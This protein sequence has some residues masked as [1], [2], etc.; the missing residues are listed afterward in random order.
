MNRIWKK[1]AA[2][3]A[4]LMI[5]AGIPAAPAET[6]HREVD[7]PEIEITAELGYD[8]VI[9]YGKAI[10]VRVRIRNWGADLEGVLGVN[11]YA[12]VREYNRYEIP[13]SVPSG[14]EKEYVLPVSVM[15]LQETFTP[16]IVVDGKVVEAVNIRAESVYNPSA[17][18]VGVLSTRPQMLSNMTITQE[19]DAL[20]RYEY[21][22]TVPLTADTF[23]D[24][25]ALMDA[26]GILVIDDIDPATLT[27]R[28]QAVLDQ[29]LRDGHFVLCGGGA[30]AARNTAYFSGITGLTAGDTYTSRYVLSALETFTGTRKTGKAP[31]VT[32]A[33]L[34]GADPVISGE[35]GQGLVYRTEAGSGRIYTM[36]F[37]AAESRMNTESVMHIFW[38]QA[39]VRFDS[40]RYNTVLYPTSKADTGSVYPGYEAEIS[41]SSPMPVAVLVII[42]MMVLAVAAWI[43]L[44]VRKKK[45]LRT[46]MWAVLPALAA[47]A[48]AL[49]LLISSGSGL[50]KTMAAYA[51]SLLQRADGSVTRSLGINAASPAAGIHT[52]SLEGA[53]L[54][55]QYN[56]D[57]YWYED[58]ENKPK[59]PTELIMCY[60][61]GDDE[62]MAV[63]SSSPWQVQAL[64]AES[65]ADGIGRVEA[66]IWMEGDGLHAS[67][68]NTGTLSLKA[69]KVISAF[70]FVSVPALKPG[71][72]A[73]VALLETPPDPNGNG[74]PKDGQMMRNSGFS[75][76]T[77]S[78]TAE[79]IEEYWEGTGKKYMIRSLA[80]SMLDQLTGGD[81]YSG[82]A[83]K[84]VFLYYAEP[85]EG[86]PLS[87]SADGKK[88][89][90]VSGTT[91][92]GVEMDYLT[93]GRT[94][95]VFHAPGMDEAVR[96]ELDGEGMPAGES[97]QNARNGY[98]KYYHTLSEV[99]TFRFTLEPAEKVEVTAL[100]I[101]MDTWYASSASCYLLNVNTGKWN[102]VNM[103]EA[104]KHPEDYLDAEGTLYCQFRP[105]TNDAYMDIPTPGVSMEG[106][107]RN[108]A[109]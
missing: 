65:T 88:L 43:I 27:D 14:A 71:E 94:G 81:Y 63:R 106:R 11:A 19:N 102:A 98:S 28:Q 38:Q 56:Q 23:P 75:L 32:V 87:V 104:V 80:G 95:V 53:A 49:I 69:G 48:A 47:A 76:Y 20:Y 92:F 82:S 86:L 89:E 85:E 24:S 93:V 55:V 22:Q 40:D 35:D 73:E 25:A 78:Y 50:N 107:I 61:A 90:S 58:E 70:G 44:R 62:R 18:L 45:D 41:V 54:K 9:T 100:S 6:M 52:Y 108:A 12:G 33:A 79:G 74:V 64:R 10:P 5:C 51:E 17:M 99:P 8:G 34:S 68:R 109:D 66:E 91:L 72:S 46:W 7:S 30:Y 59:E 1:L 2:A 77:M 26:F 39:L 36:A 67:I 83:A 97:P 16:E 101:V 21:W 60:T 105:N 103:N 37:E 42:G 96:M 4:A 3:L 84:G 13:V 15:A 29:W 57:F 31:K